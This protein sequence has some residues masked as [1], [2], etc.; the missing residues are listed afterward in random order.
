MAK[1][2]VEVLITLKREKNLTIYAP[3]DDA[4]E[5]KVVDLVMGWGDDIESVEIL[6]MEEVGG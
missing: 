3:D 6:S 1:Y 5:E 2:E 4:A